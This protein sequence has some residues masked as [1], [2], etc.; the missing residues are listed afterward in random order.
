MRAINRLTPKSVQSANERKL[1]PDGQGLY[2][3]VDGSKRWVFVFQW[4]GKRRELGL[5]SE[6]D[7]SL[8]KAREAARQ[9][10]A[11]VKAGLNPIEEKQRRRIVGTTFAEA[12]EALILSR[13]AGWTNAKHRQQWRNTLATYAEDLSAVPVAD[14]TTDH[15]VKALKPIWR[16]KAET[17][18]RVRM[19]IENVLDYAK[20][21]GWRS[22][23]NPASWRGHLAHLLPAQS[24]L[25]RGHHAALPFDL[26]PDFMVALRERTGV[27]ARA[28][29][30]TVLT[31]VR[32]S[33]T[34]GAVWSEFDFEKAVWTIP[35]ERMK[36]KAVHRVPL[37]DDAVALLQGMKAL[38][39]PFVFPGTGKVGTLSNMAMDAVLRRMK[40]EVTVHGFRSTFRDWAGERTDHPREIAEAALAHKVG[41]DVERAYRRGDALEKR[42]ALMSDWALYLR[43]EVTS[44]V[45]PSQSAE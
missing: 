8:A 23:E 32:T 34:L 30:F 7:V 27:A 24:K 3:K 43:G 10:R 1:Y 4:Q 44:A 2:L 35:A 20:A 25:T 6:R 39:S 40:V 15:V 42:R 29:E 12:A 13:E 19:R 9:A 16:S 21:Q 31:S 37:S 38:G 41:N 33:E 28:L 17:A 14:V 36:A 22:G 26:A 5:G 11:L 45:P 18:R